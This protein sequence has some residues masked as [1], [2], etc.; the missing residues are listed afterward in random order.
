MKRYYFYFLIVLFLTIIVLLALRQYNTYTVPKIIWMYWDTEEKPNIIHR[1]HDYNAKAFEGWDVRFLNRQTMYKYVNHHD[2]PLK[3][4]ELI[5][6]HKADWLRLHLLKQYGGCWIDASIIFNDPDAMNKIRHASVVQ[7]SNLTGF[8]TKE[9]RTFQHISGKT[10]PLV[11]DNWF[12]MAPP[13]S[14]VIH[15]WYSE[16]NKA[17]AMGFLNYKRMLERTGVDIS[18]IHFKGPDDVYLTQH[19]CIQKVLQRDVPTLP[20]MYFLTSSD[21]MFKIQRECMWKNDC[22]KQKLLD[23]AAKRL[24]YIKL[25][26]ELRDIGIDSYFW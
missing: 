18:A 6:Q 5:V 22:V 19:M 16:F 15:A 12:I 3:Y 24:P 21:S 9:N 4:N 1:I 2:L 13:N 17:I 23:P 25:T 11:V 26:K 14:P 10:L 7:R 8:Q 20:S